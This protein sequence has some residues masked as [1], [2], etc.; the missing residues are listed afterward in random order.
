MIGISWATT[1][2]AVAQA[3]PVWVEVRD[4]TTGG[5]VADADISWAGG[6]AKTDDSGR[7]RIDLPDDTTTPITV[8]TP[9][10]RPVERRLTTPSTRLQTVWLPPQ[11]PG[12]EVVVEGHRATGD[13]SRQVLDAEQAFE[14]P[15]THDDVLRLVQALPG[16]AVQRE[17]APSAGDLSIR[18]ADP[19]A[20]RVLLDGIEL[21]YLYHFNQ[22]ASV[23][24]ASQLASLE[25]LP[26]AYGPAWGDATGGIVAATTRTGAPDAVHGSAAMSFVTVGGDLSLPLPGRWWISAAARRS[27]FDLLGE[28]SEQYPVWPR[29]HDAQLR[30]GHG[31][32]EAGSGVFLALAGDA[33]SRAAGELDVLDPVSAAAVP[34]VDFRQGFHVAGADGRWANG[35]AVIAWVH[36]RR[37][38]TLGGGGEER[39]EEDRLDGRVVHGVG[40]ARM[41]WTVGAEGRLGSASLAVS[42]PT[43]DALAVAEEAPLLASGTAV[44]GEM[45]VPRFAAFASLRGRDRATTVE[46]GIRI[47]VDD[48]GAIV[49]PRATASLRVG[50]STSVRGGGGMYAQ[51]PDPALRIVTPDL[52]TSR[53]LQAA[54]GVEQTVA[55]RLVASVEAWTTSL[56][57]PVAVTVGTLPTAWPSGSAAG[58][59]A[60]GRYRLRERFFV[61]AW[62]SVGR[63]RR[64][65][66]AGE[67]HPAD[68]DQLVNAGAVA[69]WE[70]G[71]WT[72]G[73][74]GRYATGLP[75]TGVVGSVYE[76][77]EDGW[78]PIP[79]PDNGERMPATV[80][81]EA[82]VA[83]AIPLRGW[84]LHMHV[85]LWFTP[86]SA[87]ALYPTWSEDWSEQGFVEGPVVLPLAG[88]RAMF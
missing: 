59:E 53:A 54:V 84:T 10:R 65:D 77:N 20:S 43:A 69:S 80:K 57:D 7:A 38:A 3:A 79:G 37:H 33:W 32:E 6:T 73:L 60:V 9:G 87:T 76:A 85:E 5:R 70:V 81:G 68:G 49:E 83:H 75:F 31:D 14:T 24:P 1:P 45:F 23:I 86:P 82:R 13:T 21:P 74:R 58:I 39:F 16:V 63:S 50:P 4:R 51:R 52:A 64:T 36:D 11:R 28:A 27:F 88:V 62:A 67:E 19:G 66:P 55:G 35:K 44:Q 42:N 34:E 18:G 48:L 15:G 71:R 30:L 56:T 46:P 25:M 29:F 41:R 26:S 61:W 47:S 17:Y 22:Y 2:W 8:S 72:L 12:V 40:P 78:A